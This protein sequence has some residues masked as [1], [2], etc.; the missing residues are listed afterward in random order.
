MDKLPILLGL[1]ALFEL[2]IGLIFLLLPSVASA[3]VGSAP[4]S[5]LLLLAGSNL[6]YGVVVLGLARLVREEDRRDPSHKL[7]RFRGIAHYLTVA[8][9]IGVVL[10]GWGWSQGLYAVPA[11][12]I[13]GLI[14]A[15][16]LIWSIT[17][18]P[19]ESRRYK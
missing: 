8:F 17:N 4:K 3:F 5:T 6:A 19:R 16:G 10:L 12:I 18:W 15:Y 9:G 11:V 1:L 7:E 2:L 14:Q 13:V